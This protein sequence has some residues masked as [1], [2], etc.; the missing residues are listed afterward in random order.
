M[1]IDE[2]NISDRNSFISFVNKLKD[3]LVTGDATSINVDLLDVLEALNRYAEDIQGYCD[4]TGQ[5]V[6]AEVP[7]WKVFADLL[8]AHQ[9]TNSL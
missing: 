2:P 5:V 3:Q 4:N 7:S 6:N 8:K 9:C 1:N